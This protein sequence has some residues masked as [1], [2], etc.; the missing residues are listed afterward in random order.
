VTTS[1]ERAVPPEPELHRA[2]RTGDHAAIERLLAA[3]ADVN[4]RADIEFDHGPHL[5]GLT[6]FLTAARS[7]DGATVATLRLLLDRGA[8]VRAR[9]EGG[10]NA[11]WYAA[12]MGMR[13][14]GLHS[15]R[16]DPE[17]VERLRFLLDAGFSPRGRC[18]NG[19]SCLCEACG[20][21][22]P[23]RVALLLERGALPGPDWNAKDDEAYDRLSRVLFPTSMQRDLS[24]PG[25]PPSSVIPLFRAAESGSRTCVDLLLAA[26]ASVSQREKTG[27][28]AL[29]HARSAEVVR[30]L[31]HAGADVHARDL[32]GHDP[33]AAIFEEATV[34]GECVSPGLIE[35]ARA[36]VEAGANPD[37]V[38][39]GSHSRLWDAAFTHNAEAVE[40]LLSLGVCP[41]ADSHGG[42]TPLHAIAWQDEYDSPPMTA[43]CERIIRAL[44][45][46]GNSVNARDEH[47]R[48][49]LHEAYYGDG[50]NDTAIRVLL[51][52]GAEDL[53]PPP[54]A[55]E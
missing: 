25:A 6:P 26:G 44:V 39:G 37:R 49:P 30:A 41:S 20:A 14:P 38:P 34:D 48:T 23:A 12:G 35:V 53:D 21:G 3:G 42:S 43:A 1:S 55:E 22:D 28:T 24:V 45:A 9:S 13:L 32:S 5:R 17:H 31:V 15:W 40:F 7:I 46:A 33:L 2:A 36:L 18:G 50:R 52:L 19:S 29:A 4:Q 47:G 8:D 54:A 11:A 10:G 51:E 27:S 16:I